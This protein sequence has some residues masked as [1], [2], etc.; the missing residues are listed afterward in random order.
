M[1]TGHRRDEFRDARTAGSGRE[2]DMLD[3]QSALST[4]SN[5][6]RFPFI[7]R[8]LAKYVEKCISKGQSNRL[9]EAV[10]SK[11]LKVFENINRM[12]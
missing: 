10:T 12:F 5:A 4:F 3:I 2:L 6:A 7:P 8:S 1:A 11:R 9:T